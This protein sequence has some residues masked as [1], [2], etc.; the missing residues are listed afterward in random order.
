MV[1]KKYTP[2]FMT[3]F[4]RLGYEGIRLMNDHLPAYASNVLRKLCVKS[5]SQLGERIPTVYNNQI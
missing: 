3:E 4:E 1:H 5:C 2:N